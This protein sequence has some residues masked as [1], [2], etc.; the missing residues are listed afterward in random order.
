MAVPWRKSEDDHK[1]D[2][3]RLKSDVVIMDRV[4]R[5]RVEMEEHVRV[6]KRV[7]TSRENLEEFGFTARCPGCTSLL[8]GTTRQA[9]TENCRRRVEVELKGAAKADAAMRR[10]KEY[11]D[12]AETNE[13]RPGRRTQTRTR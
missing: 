2:G 1:M 7:C 3:E 12:R 6:P 4:H 5:E 9:H 11:Q 13:N 8:R 10:M